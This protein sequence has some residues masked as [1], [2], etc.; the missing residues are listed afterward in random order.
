MLEE[1]KVAELRRH[2]RKVR[3]H[4][5]EMIYAAKS[6]NPGSALSA[7]DIIVYLYFH[8]MRVR[9]QQPDW[10]ERDRFVASKGHIAPALYA[11][12]AM[13]RFFD[14]SELTTFRRFNSR[15]QTH[16]EMHTLPGIDFPSGSLAQGLSGAVGMALGLRKKKIDSQ[17]YVIVGDG[18]SQEGQIW[19]AA[20]SGGHY[21]LGNI[22]AFLDANKLQ[23]DGAVAT[24]MRMEPHADKWRAFGWNVVE[25]NGHDYAAID[26][27]VETVRRRKDAPGMVICNTIK[28]KG[29]PFMEGNNAWH[30]GAHLTEAHIK[31]AMAALADGGPNDR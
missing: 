22:T 21:G 19:E 25:A 7:V 5:I 29:V 3:R 26:A 15:L 9:P 12:M 6:G 30:V 14:E 17:T 16:P 20:M 11:C 28:G 4:V 24:I 1:K 27:A 2:A 10:M 13:L 31:E 8:A 18:E 23:G